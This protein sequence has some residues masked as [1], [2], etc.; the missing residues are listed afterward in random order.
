MPRIVGNLDNVQLGSI[1][2]KFV[3]P[4]LKPLKKVGFWLQ[5]EI[6]MLN[7]LVNT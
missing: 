7:K 5:H 1:V 4:G 3:L 6:S 2:I